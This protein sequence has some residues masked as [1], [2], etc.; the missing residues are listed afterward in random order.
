MH[1][2]L[3]VSLTVSDITGSAEIDGESTFTGGTAL[4]SISRRPVEGT[5]SYETG[6]R[7]YQNHA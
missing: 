7:L 2:L 6:R 5:L 1:I 4:L 3:G